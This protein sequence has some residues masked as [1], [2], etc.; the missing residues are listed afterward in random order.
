[1]LCWVQVGVVEKEEIRI[2]KGII[3]TRSTQRE[4]RICCLTASFVCTSHQKG[5]NPISMVISYLR[6]V[7]PK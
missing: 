6:N 1:M 4:S 7:L 3:I 5:F 2:R